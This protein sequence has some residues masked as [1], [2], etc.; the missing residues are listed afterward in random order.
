MKKPLLLI[1]REQLI[2]DAKKTTGVQT[3]RELRQILRQ[4]LNQTKQGRRILNNKE[5]VMLKIATLRAVL[6]EK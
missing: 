2:A 3:L 6:L 5:W 1:N 4:G